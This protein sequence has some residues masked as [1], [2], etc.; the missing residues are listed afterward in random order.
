MQTGGSPRTHAC[1]PARSI[2]REGTFSFARFSGVAQQMLAA[3]IPY[4]WHPALGLSS[5]RSALT[6]AAHNR[7]SLEPP[8]QTPRRIPHCDSVGP[9]DQRACPH[10]ARAR[11]SRV[12]VAVYAFCL[13]NNTTALLSPPVS[14]SDERSGC[15]P[16]LRILSL[17]GGRGEGEPQPTPP[18]PLALRAAGP[19]A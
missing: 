12:G 13:S 19:R 4:S 5:G 17:R 16:P 10:T 18:L 6:G 8:P 11:G 14:L 9:D 15:E 2:P 1:V 7:K 3:L